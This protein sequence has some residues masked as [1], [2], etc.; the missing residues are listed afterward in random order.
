MRTSIFI[1]FV[2]ILLCCDTLSAQSG[3]GVSLSGGIS[4]Q[5]SEGIN[6]GGLYT[7]KV[8]NLPSYG[9]GIVYNGQ[10]SSSGRLGFQVCTGFLSK[11]ASYFYKDEISDTTT[12]QSIRQVGLQF[13]LS[14]KVF[15]GFFVSAGMDNA[16]RISKIDSDHILL[17]NRKSKYDA[18][19]ILSVGYRFNQLELTLIGSQSFTPISYQQVDQGP[20]LPKI[21]QSSLKDQYFHLRGTYYF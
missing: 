1:L 16:Y 8:N 20:D 3:F 15:K 5:K 2:S 18:S 4:K 11:G 21:F 14:Y 10:F 12:S 17:L 7:F 13:S 6:T 9:L 19:T